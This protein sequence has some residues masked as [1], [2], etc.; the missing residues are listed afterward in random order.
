MKW[1]S[2]AFKPII[3]KNSL[4]HRQYTHLLRLKIENDRMKMI[5]LWKS[6]KNRLAEAFPHVDEIIP[7]EKGEKC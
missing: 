3:N 7:S 2:S 5:L 6:Y 4:I 1:C